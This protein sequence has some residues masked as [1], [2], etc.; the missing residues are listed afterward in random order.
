MIGAVGSPKPTS[1]QDPMYTDADYGS[2]Y[3]LATTRTDSVGGG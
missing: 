2:A 1:I 3:D